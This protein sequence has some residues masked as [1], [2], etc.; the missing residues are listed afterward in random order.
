M[1]STWING[2]SKAYILS[3]NITAPYPD[4]HNY[5]LQMKFKLKVALIKSTNLRVDQNA[6][7]NLTDCNQLQVYIIPYKTYS[8]KIVP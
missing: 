1:F 7:K 2:T 3:L 8:N 5:L 6:K 4:H